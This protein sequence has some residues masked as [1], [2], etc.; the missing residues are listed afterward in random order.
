[1]PEQRFS[2]LAA[3]ALGLPPRL[4]E[5][6]LIAVDGP[7]GAGKTRF[8]EQLATALGAP[9]VHTDDLLKGWDDQFTFWTRLEEKVLA[10]LRKGE[11]ATYQPYDWEK[12]DFVGLPITVLPAQAVVLEGMSAARRQIRPELTLAIYVDAPPMVRWD[13]AISRDGDDSLAY[14]KY[15]E[16][17]RA[18]EDRHFAVDETAA[19]ADLLVDGSATAPDGRYVSLAR[20]GWAR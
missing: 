7:S 9:V 20:T 14:R 2:D 6:R 4:G 15:L 5:V 3:Y 13:R 11:T 1:V 12:A 17:W 19:H 18:A 16:R 10:P 8:A